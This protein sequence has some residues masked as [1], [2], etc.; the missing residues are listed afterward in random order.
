MEAGCYFSSLWRMGAPSQP[1]W[2]RCVRQLMTF[3]ALTAECFSFRE[4]LDRNYYIVGE[5]LPSWAQLLYAKETC[6]SLQDKSHPTAV[7]SGALCHIQEFSPTFWHFGKITSVCSG[8]WVLRAWSVWQKVRM[9][10]GETQL[11]PS[12]PL[13]VS[14]LISNTGMEL[15]NLPEVPQGLTSWCGWHDGNHTSSMT[16]TKVLQPC[17][18]TR[19]I[20]S[21]LRHFKNCCWQK[22]RPS[23]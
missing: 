7:W 16:Q 5:L 11:C 20:F 21:L 17:V 9:W 6:L 8:Y 22:Q 4:Q 10:G 18:T 23:K 2:M 14:Q 1:A 13:P 12:E 15:P 19:S 3:R